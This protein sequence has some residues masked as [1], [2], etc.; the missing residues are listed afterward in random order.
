[1]RV[2]ERALDA[3]PVRRYRSVGELEHGLRES[4]DRPA[5]VRGAGRG[6]GRD[7]RN[8]AVVSAC[9]SSSAATALVLLVAALIVWTR[10]ST[11]VGRAAVGHARGRAAV[12]GHLERTCRTLPRRRAHR[13]TDLDAGPDRFAAGAVVDVGDAVPRSAR[14]RWSRSASSCAWTTSSRRRCWS[15]AARMAGPIGVRINAG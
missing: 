14:R 3:D 8:S 5:A 11:P 15:F 13:S 12:Q 10:S 1:M 2:V 4:L 7:T 9:R 6:T